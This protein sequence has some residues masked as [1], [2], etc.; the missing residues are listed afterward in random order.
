MHLAHRFTLPAHLDVV[1]PVFSSLEDIAPCWPGAAVT[2]NSGE[3]FAGT[4]KVKL[5]PLTLTYAGGGTFV[6]RDDPG[7]TIVIRSQ[8][9]DERGDGTVTTTV[10]ATLTAKLDQTEVRVETDLELTGKPARLGKGVVSDASNRLVD[11]FVSCL[12]GRFQDRPGTED[13]VEGARRAAQG[14]PADDRNRDFAARPRTLSARSGQ[15]ARAQRRSH[16][17]TITAVGA[18]LA[19]RYGKYVGVMAVVFVAVRVLRS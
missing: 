5:G 19:K 17:D 6:A 4:V 9:S 1:W 11:Q 18:P 15:T 2:E 7:R 14:R 10:T 16:L 12:A 3:D 8:G 13:S